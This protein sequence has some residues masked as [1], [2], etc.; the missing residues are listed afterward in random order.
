MNPERFTAIVEA[1]GADPKRWPEA[2]R[3]EAQAFAQRPEAADV[4]AKASEIDALLDAGDESTPVSLAF[5]RAAVSAAPSHLAFARTAANSSAG[6]SPLS[7]RPYAAMAAC[8]LLG[9]VLGFSGG[10]SALEADVAALALEIALSGGET[11]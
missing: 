11:G 4:L 5:I 10:R 1:Y 7:W 8:A 2:E 6:S 3:A 9:L